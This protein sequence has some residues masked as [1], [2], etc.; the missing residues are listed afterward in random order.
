MTSVIDDNAQERARGALSPK[1]LET[2]QGR[3]LTPWLLLFPGV[4]LITCF[5]LLPILNLLFTTFGTADGI[6]ATYR[7]F[8]AS[9]LNRIVLWRTFEVAAI[10]TALCLALGFPA[11]YFIAG[12]SKAVRSVLIVASVFPLLT[13]TVVRSFAWLV[14]LGREGIVNSTL[15]YLGMIAEPLVLIYTQTSVVIGL[16]YLF[17]PLMILSLVGV[18]EGLDRDLIHASNSLG[19]NSGATFRQ[20]IL[21]M[22]VPGLIV[23]SVLVFTGSFTAYTTPVLL[24]GNSQMMMG[25]LLYQ[26][27]MITFDWPAASTV[28]CVMVV[29]TIVV[30][31]M[32]NRLA[33]FLNPMTV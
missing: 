30:L 23:G 8:L 20:V 1:G 31:L 29:V 14:I 11:A 26:R 27:A 18:L 2:R 33:R 24:G 6:F 19:A 10:S 3:D 32:M 22:A 15:L 9:G 12:S 13:G 28:A 25:T 21:P 17:T 16:V 5:L 4:L 7:R